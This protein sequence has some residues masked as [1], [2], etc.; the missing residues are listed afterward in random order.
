MAF[1]VRVPLRDPFPVEVGKLFN[2]VNVIENGGTLGSGGNGNV[3]AGNRSTAVLVG[4]AGELWAHAVCHN[5]I[6]VHGIPSINIG[7]FLWVGV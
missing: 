4:S 1:G 6:G 5:I 3:F 2:E 7:L